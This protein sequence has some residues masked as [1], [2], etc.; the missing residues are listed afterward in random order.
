[1]C[2]AR[3]AFIP[4][5]A[6]PVPVTAAPAPQQRSAGASLPRRAWRF[7]RHVLLA[8]FIALVTYYGFCAL[9]LLAYS[10]VFP[11]TTGVQVQRRVESF[12]EEDAYD[13]RYEPVPYAEMSA[14]LPHA[15][16][17][18]EDTRFY[19]HGGADWE[20]IQKAARE[21]I[22]RGETY[23]GGSTITQQLVKNL[24]QTT[25]SSYIRKALELPL[26]YLAELMLSKE[27][28]LELYLNVIEFE[29]GVYG[30]EAAAQHH[31]GTSA[32]SLSRYQSATLAAIVPNPRERTPQ[33]MD[34]YTSTILTRMRQMGH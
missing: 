23:R 25:H 28:I 1:M 26:T 2:A 33:R 3:L 16:V 13:K 29:R 14:H 6:R 15:L 8:G 5:P 32:E 12:F 27:R 30:V 4:P 21:N 9:C 7:V 31:Y 10:V 20:A 19:E 22:A 11:P 24:F 17:A 34:G 18:A